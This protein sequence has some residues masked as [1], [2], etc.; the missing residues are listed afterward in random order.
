MN[1]LEYYI[2][3]FKEVAKM[4]SV[5]KNLLANIRKMKLLKELFSFWNHI[6]CWTFRAEIDDMSQ[7]ASFL[8]KGHKFL[9]VDK[10][11]GLSETS[12]GFLKQ[13]Q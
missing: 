7:N 2:E 12:Q 9:V 10:E 6:N 5:G 3:T 8:C 13:V 1:Q 11:V 4:A